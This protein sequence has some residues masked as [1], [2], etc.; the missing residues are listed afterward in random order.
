L[1]IGWGGMEKNISGLLLISLSFADRDGNFFSFAG[2]VQGR[3][4]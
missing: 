2:E 3:S 1:V 4:L